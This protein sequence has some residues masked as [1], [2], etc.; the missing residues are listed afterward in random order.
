MKTQEESDLLT[1]TDRGTP[2]GEL[3]RRYWQPV[4]LSEE[5]PD[6]G[7]PIPLKIMGE[8]LVLYRDDQ[9]KPGLMG[10]HCP[11]RGADLSYGR[12]EDGGL[13][14]IYHGWLFDKTGRCLDQPWEPNGGEHRDQIRHTAYPCH[15]QASAIFAY[16]G[17]GDPPFFPNYEFLMA[18]PEQTYADKLF[19]EANYLQMN[20]GSFDIPHLSFL[21]YTYFNQGLSNNRPA[22]IQ[23]AT[24]DLG[25]RGAAPGL[26]TMDVELTE[27]G[28]RN[29]RIRRDRGPDEYHLQVNEFVLPNFIA[30]PSPAGS[31][32]INWHVPIDDT[33]H[34]KFTF[35]FDREKPI[36]KEQTKRFRTEMTPDFRS[37]RNK[38]NRY[39]QD[40]ESMNKEWYCGIAQ[41]FG[42]Q[43]LCVIEGAGPVQD[44]TQ[45][46]LASSDMPIVVARKIRIK[47]IRDLQEGREPKNVIRDPG[48]NK[49]R[50]VST[51]EAVPSTKDWKDYV[52]TEVEGRI[53]F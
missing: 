21:H 2:M 46:H 45:E 23:S 11:H 25:R 30:F 20:E 31:Y 39:L 32:G 9:G 36:P 8:E 28:L 33:H 4:A 44:R 51:S 18:P 12:V 37:T 13:R 53:R 47:A 10:I 50:I 6:G 27:Y 52:K 17:P 40:R 16:M 48:M 49:F 1:R 35:I 43:D 41:N 3:M 29:F 15:E 5:L 42:A 7:A 34:W 22:S 19:H 26:E 24:V 14:C 38:S